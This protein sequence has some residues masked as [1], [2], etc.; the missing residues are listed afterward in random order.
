MATACANS[1]VAVLSIH[2]S[3]YF[4][5]VTAS[6]LSQALPNKEF[7]NN[8]HNVANNRSSFPG[9][10]E[11]SLTQCYVFNS[12]KQFIRLPGNI[13]PYLLITIVTKLFTNSLITSNDISFDDLVYCIPVARQ[14][15]K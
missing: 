7:A 9:S 8:S 5:M 11:L 14:H 12:Y 15:A 13:R 2:C 3:K 4:T 1:S 6:V 10:H